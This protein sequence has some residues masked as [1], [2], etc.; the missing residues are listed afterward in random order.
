MMQ[1]IASGYNVDTNKF[2]RV[3]DWMERVKK[4]TQPHFDEAHK[5]PMRLRAQILKDVKSKV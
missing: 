4:E 2:P 1:P 3:Q 5:V